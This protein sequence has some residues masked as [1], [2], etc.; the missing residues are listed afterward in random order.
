MTRIDEAAAET[1]AALRTDVTRFGDTFFVSNL[2][3]PKLE[4]HGADLPAVIE[5]VVKCPEF[6]QA[7]RSEWLVERNKLHLLLVYFE[8]ADNHRHDTVPFLQSLSGPVLHEALVAVFQIWGPTRGANRRRQMPR[9]LYEAW[10]ALI[11]EDPKWI[12]DRE[13]LARYHAAGSLS[14][15]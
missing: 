8:Q 14:L 11:V 5:S 7:L 6:E 10:H 2:A 15:V 12:G 4:R 13:G 1:W 9:A 3:F